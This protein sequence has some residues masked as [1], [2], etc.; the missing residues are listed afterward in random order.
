MHAPAQGLDHSLSPVDLPDPPVP[1]A[2]PLRWTSLVIALAA[3]TLALLN[4]HAIRGWSY[5]LPPNAVSV[6]VVGAAEAWY[7][8][9]DPIGLNRPVATMHGWWQ[10]FKGLR[11]LS[12]LAT[13]KHSLRALGDRACARPRAPAPPG[14]RDR[15]AA[16]S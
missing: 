13:P 11:W 6:R 12:P 2:R 4:A 10:S 1:L 14:C 16:E 7:D 8:L 3:L 5:T 9:L 15:R